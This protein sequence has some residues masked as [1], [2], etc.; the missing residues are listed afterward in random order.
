MSTIDLLTDAVAAPVLSISD[1][2]PAGC[3]AVLEKDDSYMFT[4][5]TLALVAM[6]DEAYDMDPLELSQGLRDTFGTEPS[7]E[8]L[9]RLMAWQVGVTTPAFY[10]DPLVF[11][12]TT[13]TLASG[14][15]TDPMDD[16]TDEGFDV[17]VQ[18]MLWAIYEM[19]MCIDGDPSINEDIE[20]I[21]A[22]AIRNVGMEG[23]E[24]IVSELYSD[25]QQ[26]R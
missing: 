16:V 21:I 1:L 9:N 7:E 15:P 4:L 23:V 17:T 12:A 13:R 18:D 24:D 2:D 20:V 19:D 14:F 8:N 10:N 26:D 25:M 11:L 6:G 3:V 22:E 5:A